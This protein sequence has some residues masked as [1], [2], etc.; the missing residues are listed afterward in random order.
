MKKSQFSL[1]AETIYDLIGSE[2]DKNESIET[3]EMHLKSSYN[4]G[5]KNGWWLANNNIKDTLR[6]WF[7]GVHNIK[8]DLLDFKKNLE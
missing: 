2:L 4:E 8:I 6:P 5:L 3:I 1:I 7:K